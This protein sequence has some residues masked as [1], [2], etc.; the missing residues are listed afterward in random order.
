[1]KKTIFIFMAL[2]TSL[3]GN[4]QQSWDFT[5]TNANDVTALKAATTEWTY[6]EASDRYENINAIDGA[7][8]AGNAVLQTTQGLKFKGAEKKIRIDVN[9]RVQ[10]AGKNVE[11]TIQNLKKGQTVTISFASTGN[12]VLT[13]DNQVNLENT[14]GF[15]PADKNTTQ[16]GTGTVA[17]DGDV[18]FSST[19]GSVNV[20]SISVSAAVD[21][22][23]VDPQPAADD[24]SVAKNMFKNQAGLQLLSGDVKYYNTEDLS[25]I[26]IDDAKVTVNT[27]DENSDIFD[28]NVNEISFCKKSDEVTPGT[29][30]N[31]GVELT[32]AAGWKE[33]LY[34]KWNFYE[35]A[36]SYN[37]YIKGGQ[38]ADFTKIDYQL[39]RKYPDYGRAD[40][41][42]LVEG[43]YD[44]KVVPVVKNAESGESAEVADKASFAKSITVKPYDRSGFAH[45]KYDSGVGAYNNDGSLKQGAKVFYVTANTAKTITTSV[46][47]DN[48]GGTTEFTGLQAII[49]GYEKGCDT[50]PVT[51]RFIGTIKAD[52][53]DSFGS[54]EEGIQV[55][56]RKA[57]SELNMTFE[58][59]GEDA[60]IHGFGFLVR[61]SKSVEFRN[62]GIMRCMDDGLSL[63]TDNSNIWIHN[64]DVYYGK[65]GSG[66]KAKGDGAIDVKSDSKYVTLSYS[67]FWD[68]GKSNMFGMKSE[69]GPNYIS[70]HHNWFDHSDSRHPRIRT[71]SVHV[72][73]NYYDGNAKYGVGVTTGSSCFAEN[74]Y[75][76][77][78]H[79]PLL[80]SK[81][82]TDAKGDGTFSGEDGG[83][84]K[85]FGNIYAENGGSSYYVPITYQTNSTSFDCYEASSRDEQVPATVKTLAGGTT[86]DNFDTNPS[87]MYSYTPDATIDVPAIVTGYYGAGRLNHGDCQFTFNNAVDDTSYDLNNA[88]SNL[89]DSYKS[90]L[91]GIF[92]EVTDE[93]GGDEPGGDE[94]GGDEPGGD[95]PT[96]TPTGT[97][98]ASFDSAPS[99]NMFT[100]GGNYGDGKITYN[101]TYYKKGVKLDS[102][103]SITFTPQQDYNMTIIMATAKS[104]R[105]VKL[106]DTVTTVSGTTNTEGAYYELAPIAITKGTQ[107]VITKGSAEGM[108]MLIKL[109]PVSQ[110]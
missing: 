13:L 99:S 86:Y 90:K 19:G 61:N 39:V 72:Y 18:T 104:G 92:D 80:S 28:G 12:T 101:E 42:G 21:P 5:A 75:F 32:V 97:I 106:N 9:K 36:I 84:I 44:V 85:S 68:T 78:A 62:F 110:K 95:D 47:T 55:K 63:D 48:K 41:V 76:R 91:V 25:D 103:G 67:H 35:G 73:N 37:V 23:P 79:D 71:M 51:F 57:D 6:T 60:T 82:G 46:V 96:P 54:S 10:L 74:N 7:L 1:M 26:S 100:V 53:V 27:K 24:H 58:G 16:T 64:M 8:T 88:L 34:L 70:Y 15:S 107:Y 69:S 52:D 102:K 98:L 59:I 20:F 66:D 30:E 50:T 109:E 17:A 93:P 38:Y 94:P 3:M 83:I 43:V 40:V 31:N 56:G 29:I 105:D 108:V 2:L 22:E 33:S 87:L 81:Q 65:K 89:I 4:A 49:S 14:S 45:F 11:I 77:H